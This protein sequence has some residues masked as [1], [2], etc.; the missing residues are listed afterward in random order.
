MVAGDG[1]LG[2]L[3]QG[4]A[5]I[6]AR[7]D[8]FSA[9]QSHEKRME[10]GAIA[11]LG[12]AGPDRVASTPACSGFVITH[13]MENVVVKR[14]SLFDFAFFPLGILLS[15]LRNDA[16]SR[17]QAVWLDKSHQTYRNLGRIA[18]ITHQG[19][20]ISPRVLVPRH[21]VN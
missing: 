2:C 3:R 4:K 10:I 13:V 15:N 8:F 9:G 11:M 21:S 14:V 19:S 7:R 16:A 17:H 1:P 12:I 6:K 18:V 5:N 20:K